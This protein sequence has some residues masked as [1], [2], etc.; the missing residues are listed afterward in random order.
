MFLE[1]ISYQRTINRGYWDSFFYVYNPTF[2]H[3]S[4]FVHFWIL[5]IYKFDMYCPNLF[6]IYFLYDWKKNQIHFHLNYLF[7]YYF[8]HIPY[9]H[10]FINRSLYSLSNLGLFHFSDIT[11][12][13]ESFFMSYETTHSLLQNVL[14]L[15][16]SHEHNNKINMTANM[17]II[18]PFKTFIIL[19]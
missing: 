10:L 15:L 4:D 18:E 2:S 5:S 9:I 11:I 17:V 3:F 12:K 14:H 8:N 1:F 7:F 6:Q 16:S 19:F 13:S